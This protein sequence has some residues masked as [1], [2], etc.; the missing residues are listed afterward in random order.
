MG[1]KRLKLKNCSLFFLHFVLFVTFLAISSCSKKSYRVVSIE[2]KKISV[3]EKY[4][5][6]ADIENFIAPYREH[7]NKDLDSVLSYCPETLDKSKGKWQTNIGNF[8]AD[9]CFES[10]NRLFQKQ[11]EKEADLCLLNHGGI[12]AVLPK[13]NVSA[14]NAFEIMPF[15]N[16]LVVIG[17]SSD[18]IMEMANYLIREKKPHPL[19]RTNI[20]INE[21]SEITDIKINGENLNPDKIY[22]VITSD[23][24]SN[25]GD[26][27]D[28]FQNPKESYDLEYK[29]RNVLIDYFKENDTL[30]ISHSKRIEV[31]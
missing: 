22:Y 29:L 18:K 27:M 20:I 26:N 8:M 31:K 12:R 16:N 6:T 1:F 19:S 10:G 13:G 5:N 25:G 2:G 28:F 15:E 21:N 11:F 14:R 17:I 30:K 9:V 3:T 7:I 4:T 24:L 23:Y